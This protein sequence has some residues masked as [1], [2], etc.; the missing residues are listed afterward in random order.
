MR[1]PKP[2]P[3]LGTIKRGALCDGVLLVLFDHRTLEPR[4]MW[5]APIAPVEARLALPGSKAR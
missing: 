5:E 2:G 4:E 1:L 3:R